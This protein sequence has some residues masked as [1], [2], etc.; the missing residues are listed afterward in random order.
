MPAQAQKTLSFTPNAPSRG[1]SRP[2]NIM[3][4]NYAQ[5][6]CGHVGYASHHTLSV[7]AL[8][9]PHNLH[10]IK[11]PQPHCA[12]KCRCKQRKDSV[13]KSLRSSPSHPTV[14][15]KGAPQ[16]LSVSAVSRSVCHRAQLIKVESCKHDAGAT[17]TSLRA[18]PSSND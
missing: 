6:S 15:P 11:W 1:L 14:R 8:S 5:S 10:Y 17:L 9:A 7:R 4:G 13:Y 18:M 3:Y 16:E 12:L 2:S